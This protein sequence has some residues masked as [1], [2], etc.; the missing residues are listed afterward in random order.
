MARDADNGP[1]PIEVFNAALELP[2]DSRASYLS[3]ACG[4]NSSLR[5]D[6]ESLLRAREK[7]GADF[8]DAPIRIASS[9][10][11]LGALF[12]GATI[13]TQL[14][15]YRLV[16]KLA[17]GGMGAVFLA[18]R[19]DEAYTKQVAIKLIH[20]GLWS[21]E[22]VG[23]FRSERQVLADL[24]HPAIARLIDGGSTDGEQPYLVMEYVDGL[25]IDRWCE[26]R[27]LDVTARLRLFLDVCEAVLYAHQN[28]VIHRDL[29]PGN[30]FVDQSGRVKLLDFG[31][32]KVLSE[33]DAVEGD[34]HTLS[35]AL[36]TPRYASPEQLA[37][38][39][40]TTASDIYSLGVL[41]YELLS[42]SSPYDLQG[43]TPTQVAHIIANEMPSLPSRRAAEPQARHLSGDLDM[44]VMK[45]LQKEP[46]RRYSTAEEFAADIRRHLAGLPVLARPDTAAYRL[47]KFVARNRALV[48]GTAAVV[49]LL[50]AA[51]ATTIAEYREARRAQRDA[52]WNAYVASLAAAESALR[53]AQVGESADHLDA[54]PPR[55]RSWEWHHLHAR[56]DRSLDGFQAHDKGI[57]R[58]LSLPHGGGVLTCSI[59]GTVKKWSGIRGGLLRT[60]G[61]FGSEVE[62]IALL[63]GGGVAAIGLNDGRV[64][65]VDLARG[66]TREMLPSGEAWAFVTA[67]V[68][69]TRLACGDFDGYVRVWNVGTGT[70]V[71]KWKAQPGLALPVYSPDG[72]VLAVGGGNGGVTLYDARS[73]ARRSEWDAHS[74]RVYSM[75]FAH[76]GEYLVTGSMDQTAKVWDVRRR[77]L[78]RTFREHHATVGSIAFDPDGE[79]VL[80]AAA[81]NRLLRWSLTTGDVHGEFHGHR[82]DV[83]ALAPSP[84]GAHL[85]SADW[86]GAVKSWEWTTDDVR[87]FSVKSEWLVPQVFAAAWD[88][89]EENVACASTDVLLRA[90]SRTGTSRR[91]FRSGLPC[92]GVAYSPDGATLYAGD[93]EGRILVFAR[94]DDPRRKETVHRGA[95]L[96]MAIDSPGNILV[97]AGADSLVKIFRLPELTL[98]REI[99]SSAAAIE[100]LAFSPNG[101]VLASCDARGAIRLWS[102]ATGQ[103]IAAADS[104]GAPV[105]DVAFDATGERLVS[106]SRSGQVRIWDD[107]LHPLR[108][109][110]A[111][112]PNL[113]CVAWSADGTRIATGGSDSVVR[114]YDESTGRQ[115]TSLHGHVAAITSLRF[116]RNDAF[117]TSTAMDGTVRVWDRG[118]E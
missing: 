7:G 52:E 13:G 39:R 95:I 50:A 5:E 3:H 48:L 31:I 114:L 96:A 12:A 14:G 54:A 85:L 27:Q 19:T 2:P 30:I 25:P 109:L 53:A 75:A 38:A 22:A 26:E 93:D 24:E 71:A 56:L 112:G 60:Y 118:E 17:T 86:R 61:P 45:A 68:D 67:N 104:A 72:D 115:V 69:G 102:V 16:R 82:A 84:D 37:G 41:L 44:I 28:L 108:T 55:L 103:P 76:D 58:I 116:A 46:A 92:H 64:L 97:T 101:D 81:D 94:E 29:K 107:E 90:W 79:H 43:K 1:D 57:T 63:S 49:V 73:H 34:I 47:A 35:A 51:L 66:S 42:G 36:F 99:A 59:D 62:S 78:V 80:T 40:I 18:E 9:A 23:R 32:A 91:L 20:P 77:E 100:R 87:T 106:V 117:L 110:V 6:V 111:S 70:L 89:K 21:A 98:L 11:M 4:D 65:L 8:L 105:K 83:S 113:R 15:P 33:S 74:R 88:S 10:E